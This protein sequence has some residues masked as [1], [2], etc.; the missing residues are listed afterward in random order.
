MKK[1]LLTI[2]IVS[3]FAVS[4][5]NQA[6]TESQTDSASVSADSSE[7][8]ASINFEKNSYDFGKINEGDKATHEFKFTNNG[9]SPLIIS[10]ATATCGC[11]VP[12]YPKEPIAPGETGVIKVVFNSAGKTGMQHKVVTL[13]TNANPST[14]ELYLTGEVKGAEDLKK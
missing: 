11:T 5:S 7:N 12:E 3:A 9:K 14:T 13:T 10:N 4:C 2:L 1:T 6:A 8:G